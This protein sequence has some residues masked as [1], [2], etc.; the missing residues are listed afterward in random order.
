M[1]AAPGT[2]AADPAQVAAVRRDLGGDGRPVVLAAGRLAA[3]KGFGTLLEAAARWQR[4][5][6]VPLLVIAG[7]GPLGPALRAQAAAAGTEVRFLGPRSDMP[8]LLAVADVVVVPSSWEGQPLIVQEALRA[9]RPL[10]ASRA[11][12]I[13]DLT[14]ADGAL[15]VPPGDPKVL[16]TAVAR[17]VDNPAEAAALAAAARRR[18]ATL[19]DEAAAVDQAAAVYLRVRPGR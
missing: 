2:P 17:L 6:P 8:V 4:R 1:V 11:G 7:D 18:A 16:A 12:G 13:A 14:G 15:L 19:P 9:G 5:D 3:Q 10:V